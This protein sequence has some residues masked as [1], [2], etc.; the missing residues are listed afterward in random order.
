MLCCV[1]YRQFT[2]NTVYIQVTLTKYSSLYMQCMCSSLYI[3]LQI[4]S[5]AF[6]LHTVYFNMS[7]VSYMFLFVARLED[8]CHAAREGTITCQ[9]TVASIML[10][11]AFSADIRAVMVSRP[12]PGA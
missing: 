2:V 6:H 12:G 11:L 7:Y 9:R 8:L 5:C 10:E 1:I 3:Q 4:T